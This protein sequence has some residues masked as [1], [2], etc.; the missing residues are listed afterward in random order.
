MHNLLLEKGLV[1]KYLGAKRLE[2]DI[3]F[4]FFILYIYLFIALIRQIRGL[5][6]STYVIFNMYIS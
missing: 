5:H 1:E 4:I 6:I 2:T 3:L